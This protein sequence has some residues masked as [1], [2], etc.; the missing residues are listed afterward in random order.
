MNRRDFLRSSLAAASTAAALG[1]AE[2]APVSSVAT[3]PAPA[4]GKPYTFP[5]GFFWGSATAAAQV[6]GSWN[7][8]GKGESVWD[9]FSHTPARIKGADTPDVACDHYV[10]YRSDIALMK[11][12]N[13]KSYRFSVSWPRIQATGSG[14]A[15]PKGVDFYKR[16]IDCVL[17]AG[18]R[19]M[20]TLYHWDL[21][22]TLEDRGGWPNRE[23]AD[24]FADYAAVVAKE[25]GDR[26][27][28]WAIFN[29]PYIFT[30]LGY[31]TGRHA[32]GKTNF[33]DFI[34]ATHTVNLAQ[35]DA[36]R[37]IKAVVP[38]SE[39]GSAFSMTPATP[40]RD[41]DADRAA[42]ERFHSITNI[43]FLEA[44]LHGRYPKAFVN[45]DNLRLLGI[46][47]GDEARMKAP[48]EWIG[49][50]Y[51]SRTKIA[52]APPRP[53]AQ[54]EALFGYGWRKCDDGPLTDIGWEVW[55][56]G[57]YDIVSRISRD[58]NHPTIEITENGASYVDAPNAHGAIPDARRIAYYRDHLVELHRAIQ[59][60]ARVRGYHAW[61][62]MDNFEW[63]E[64]YTQRF[65]LV[66]VDFRDQRRIVKQSGHWYS[67][68]A[69]RNRV[70]A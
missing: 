64:G 4:S 59:D 31:L 63:A 36:F 55:P 54:G 44:A 48:L 2:A 58:Y 18:I 13:L 35:G 43:W 61:S 46:R 56:K 20:C 21:P 67:E 53:N 65:G 45:D 30:S 12:L 8:D 39:V 68:V 15:N 14:A 41:T 70:L 57:I 16:M 25:L 5:S 26:I 24:R 6:E 17:E 22:Q 23:T 62:I 66:Y 51:Y 3:I 33:D 9:R 50:N 42:A 32:P 49:I 37:A 38:K 7:R 27:P 19:P 29:E 69:A 10:R 11:Q 52:D 47:D 40:F 34:R 1:V 28:V 60:G